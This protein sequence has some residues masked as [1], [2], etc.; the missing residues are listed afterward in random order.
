MMNQALFPAAPRPSLTFGLRRMPCLA[1]LLMLMTVNAVAQR[2]TDGATPLALSPGTPAGSYALSGFDNVNLYNGNLGFQLPLL[3]IGG[4]GAA[5]HSIV[6][7]IKR[8]WTIEHFVS[9]EDVHSYLPDDDWWANNDPVIGGGA[10]GPGRIVGRYGTFGK[11]RCIPSNETDDVYTRTLTRLTFTGPDG[12]EIELRDQLSGGR[13][14]APICGGP[15]FSRG[16]VFV[17]ADGSAM[18][19]IADAVIVDEY[20]LGAWEPFYPSGYLLLRD[21]T[22]YRFNNGSVEWIRDRNGNVLTFSYGT[23]NG[24]PWMIV[25][26]ALNHQV[27]VSSGPNL[28]SETST[29]ITYQGFGGQGRTIRVV[30]T[31]LTRALRADQTAQTLKGLFPELDGDNTES[32]NTKV[33]GSVALPDGRS[34]TFKYNSY[35]ELARV[36]LPTGAAIEY[37]YA[38]GFRDNNTDGVVSFG[39]AFFIGGNDYQV[40]RRVVARRVY[41]NGGT[42]CE[43][44]TTYSRPESRAENSTQN[45]GYVEV[46]EKDGAHRVLSVQRH[47]FNG[48][49]G[50][51]LWQ[52]LTGAVSY[53][54]WDEGR[55]Y[56]TEWYDTDGQ[57]AMRLLRRVEQT[58]QEGMPLAANPTTKVNAR[59]VETR[60][61]LLDVTP[62]LVS[63]QTAIS[64][65]DGSI[66]FDRYNN[67]TDVWEYDY[68]SDAPG[69][70]L[71]HTH[72]DYVT[73]YGGSA[74]DTVNPSETTPDVAATIHLRSLP[75]QQSVYEATAAN[76]VERSRTTYEYDNYVGGDGKHE[77]LTT[78]TNIAGLCTQYTAAGVCSNSAPAGYLTRG[79]VTSVT[80]WLLSAGTGFSAYQQYD[81]A[82]NVVRMI[83]ARGSATAF[84]FA[85][86]FGSPDGE[87]RANLTSQLVELNGQNTYAFATGMT[88][89]L[90]QMSYTQ[91]DYYVGAAVN[92][93]DINGVIS[94]AA[95]GS[96]GT[97]ALDR[98]SQLIRAVNTPAQS[99]TSF[100]YDDANRMVTTQ[101]DLSIDKRLKSQTLFDKLGRAVETR[102][103]EGDGTYIAISHIPFVMVQDAQSRWVR[104][105]KVSNPFRAGETARWT[106]TTYDAQGRM[107]IVRTPDNAFVSTD[108]HGARVLAT[109]QAGKQR[110]SQTNALGQL[111]DIWEITPADDATVPVTFPGQAGVRAGYLTHYDYDTL[112]NLKTVAQRIGAQGVTQT[113]SFTY[114]SLSRLTSAANPES[115]TVLYRY[116]E[117][118]NLEWKTAPRLLQS[119]VPIKTHYSYDA[120]NRVVRR[121]YND[122]TPTVN[123]QYDTAG[124]AHAK[125]QLT[126]VSSSVSVTSY[127][128]FDALGRITASSQATNGQTYSMSYE[129]DLAGNLTREIYP[130]GRVIQHTFDATGR[131]SQVSGTQGSAAPLT[132]AAVNRYA[133]HGAIERMTLGNGLIEQT[134]FNNRLQPEEIRLGSSANPS[135]KLLLQYDYGTNANN[136]N[137]LKQT[138][139]LPG[140]A[141]R[142]VQTYEYDSLNRLS[143]ARE[144]AN[145]VQSWQQVYGYDRFGNRRLKAGTTLPLSQNIEQDA[146]NNPTINQATN[147]IDAG[148]GYSYDDNA[149][150]SAGN[151]T[152]APGHTY[153][154]DA[155]NRLVSSNHAP[156][157][158]QVNPH[159]YFYDGDG[160]RV[161]KVTAN[162]QETTIFVYN[163]LGQMI[164]E[165]N[166]LPSASENQT[167]YLT[168]D[169]LGTPRVATNADGTVKAR[170]DYLP[171]GE[172]IN[173]E[174]GGRSSVT[175][176]GTADKVRQKFTGYERDLGAGLD[177]AK[178]RYY[179]NAQGRF[180]SPDRY[181]GSANGYAPQT[182][183][184]YTYCLNR[185]LF[186]VD[187]TGLVWLQSNKNSENFLY[188]PDDQYKPEDYEDYTV[189]ENGTIIILT[190]PRG[191]YKAG[192][193]V[194]LEANGTFSPVAN[195]GNIAAVTVYDEPEMVYLCSR[196]ADIPFNSIFGLPHNWLRTSQKEAGAGPDYG[197]VPGHGGVDSPYISKM[198]MNDHTGESRLS[199]A[200][201]TPIP[202]ANVDIVNSRLNIGQPLGRFSTWNNC[203][204]VS[205]Q[206]L[207]EAGAFQSPG[208]RPMDQSTGLPVGTTPAY[209][210]PYPGGTR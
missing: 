61:T 114:D 182:W 209:A 89:A 38:A 50:D 44:E 98:P 24:Q 69:A 11:N 201:C 40:Y 192:D 45:D 184:R 99:Q 16:R 67:P 36:E 175:E 133:A 23:S 93:E 1:I 125:G 168:N 87:A 147:R 55:Q 100:I 109:D 106:T 18:T 37:D 172:E 42:N 29:D 207:L 7:P 198:T 196:P 145:T 156:P 41:P 136:G 43:T 53:P 146:L 155:E 33:I 13:S 28:G 118:G 139:T 17:S 170:H 52:G 120:L 25:T 135:N 112:N 102:Q 171:F 188:V 62:A 83:D 30:H 12:T 116:D 70:L 64:P 82:G 130:T 166:N 113:R 3:A 121:E 81:I 71:R 110:L 5:Q 190:E 160:R 174:V 164:A 78:R 202:E 183:N 8:K 126:A 76:E 178:A 195:A 203:W 142:L 143:Q 74:Y 46:S 162:G 108:Y 210:C 197:G 105:M 91:Y 2:A 51:S 173:S 66:G 14:K 21:G 176:Y 137:V 165:Y 26:D 157:N 85:D 65:I 200:S 6:L 159:T 163:A 150:N 49:A 169:T 161:K 95:Y 22:R 180:T 205:H 59:V 15:G 35:G 56:K 124:I 4:R 141:H 39:T 34:Y 187:P 96:N 115:G 129:Y 101:S 88:N 54:A 77:Q 177:Y 194:S 20:R 9:P 27:K 10:F 154:Y 191:S 104:A 189:I 158:Q 204:T 167:S 185:P 68:G 123:Y 134:S 149:H 63:K 80:R 84:D 60:T 206:I 119:G 97:D 132:Y 186:Y 111:T 72:T 32:F 47:Y 73:T 86:R 122:G 31:D 127:A 199:T 57:N 19:F 90:G 179:S 58:W 131:L 94:S 138:I 153:S 193:Y 152:S 103:Y 48:S 107:T 208:P 144:T 75:L 151:L 128:G 92:S 181:W 117:N 140:L 148:Q 79:N